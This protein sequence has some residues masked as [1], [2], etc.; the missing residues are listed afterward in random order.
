MRAWGVALLCLL[1]TALTVRAAVYSYRGILLDGSDRP[2]S[3]APTLVVALY[4]AAEG[5]NPLWQRKITVSLDERGQF[6]TELSEAVGSAVPGGPA[7]AIGDVVVGRRGEPLYLEITVQGDPDT[8]LPRTRIGAVPRANCAEHAL[9]APNGFDVNGKFEAT[10]EVSCRQAV[11]VAKDVIAHGD[12]SVMGKVAT[13][14]DL[15]VLSGGPV[16][17][18]GA[19]SV[20][21]AVRAEKAVF[22][23]GLV[24]GESASAPQVVVTSANFTVNGAN[25]YI[26]PG[27]IVMWPYAGDVPDGWV[28]CNGQ[29]YTNSD[30]SVG[31]TPDL[32]GR[33]ILGAHPDDVG[34][35][36][37]RIGGAR[38]VQLTVDTLPAHTHSYTF[39]KN[40]QLMH[41]GGD[42]AYGNY[43]D[44][45]SFSEKATTP[46]PFDTKTQETKGTAHNNLPPYWAVRYIMKKG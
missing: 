23:N 19:L 12:V 5:G 6:T 9:S 25:A 16:D 34:Y 24:V 21:N 42:L 40:D 29:K 44:G 43:K 15:A 3:G 18:A 20:T 37:G 35:S 10:A 33:F 38:T 4:A 8:V 27:T 1:S 30:G 14:D 31:Q 11:R 45:L 22:R 46:A 17:V 7:A 32:T 41:G 2:L 36:P 39:N 13:G 26:Q 28:E